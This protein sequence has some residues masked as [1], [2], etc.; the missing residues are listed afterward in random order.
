MTARYLSPA[1]VAQRLGVSRAFAYRMLKSMR[2]VKLE[3]T[4]RVAE[5]VLEEYV[6][7]RTSK[8]N[9]VT[10]SEAANTL[11]AWARRPLRTPTG[12]SDERSLHV[13]AVGS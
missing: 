7:A 9:P 4:V 5:E 13:H 1:Q 8:P 10:S 11:P 2:V 3:R 6:A 12:A